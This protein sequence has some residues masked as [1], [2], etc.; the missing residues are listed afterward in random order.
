MIPVSKLL[1]CLVGQHFSFSKHVS[2]H[3]QG[4]QQIP[5][6]VLKSSALMILPSIIIDDVITPITSF[7][8]TRGTTYRLLRTKHSLNFHGKVRQ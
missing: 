3:R 4:R 6:K 1:T 2:S 5:A 8:S 7:V